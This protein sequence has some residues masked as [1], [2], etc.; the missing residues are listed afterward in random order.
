MP[1][2]RVYD[3][4]AVGACLRRW[5]K[6]ASQNQQNSNS[7]KPFHVELDGGGGEMLPVGVSLRRI[8]LRLTNWNTRKG[9]TPDS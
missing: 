4:K 6:N 8:A 1:M 9:G 3:D 2:R 5:G 7:Q